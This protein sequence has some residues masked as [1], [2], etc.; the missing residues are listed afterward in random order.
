MP[1]IIGG[2]EGRQGSI[3]IAR[4][5]GRNTVRNRFHYDV[6]AD[7]ATQSRDQIVQADGLPIVGLTVDPIYGFCI[8]L[9]ANRD[10]VR[11]D[12]WHLEYEFSTEAEENGTQ[13]GDPTQWAVIAELQFEVFDEVVRK[14]RSATPKLFQNSAKSA[15]EIGLTVPRTILRRDFTQFEPESTTIDD[16][17]DRN[18]TI[19]SATFLGRAAKTLLLNIRSAKIGYYYGT[20][21]W[22]VEYSM[23]YRSDTWTLKMLDVGYSYLDGSNNRKPYYDSDGQTIILGALNGSGGKVASQNT[24]PSELS[25]ERYST[26]DFSTFIRLT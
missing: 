17:E 19:N 3:S 25:F 2:G 20:R 14:D 12:L 18:N 1:T 11:A 16:F 5:N 21:C 6:L 23:K 22:L 7:S 8:G 13:M 24:D 4:S 10:P 9:N 26:L 15:F